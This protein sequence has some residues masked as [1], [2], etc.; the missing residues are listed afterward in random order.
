MKKLVRTTR[1]GKGRNGHYHIVYLNEDD[2]YGFTSAVNGQSHLVKWNPPTQYQPPQ[3]DQLGNLIAEEVPESPGFFEILPAEDGHTHEGFEEIEVKNPF[4]DDRPDTE[5]AQEVYQLFTAAAGIE[6]ESIEDGELAEEFVAG[7]QWDEV[8]L[9]KLTE[10][11]RAALT[12]NYIEH[13]IDE[14][15]GYQRNQRTD[16]KYLPK[17]G[18]DQVKADIFTHIAKHVLDKCNYIYEESEQFEDQAVPGRGIVTLDVSFDK[19]IRGDI[20]VRHLPWKDARF[21]PHKKK[22]LSDLEYYVLHRMY[23]HDHLTRMYEDK[24]DE[25]D[26]AVEQLDYLN[27]TDDTTATDNFSGEWRF[28]S[29]ISGLPMHN[30]ARKEIRVLECW[31]KLY[32]RASVLAVPQD[33]FYVSGLGWSKKDLDSAKTIP[34]MRVVQRMVTKIRITK[35]CR[36]V[37]LADELPADLP[38]DD[39]YIA[40][41]YA[42][43][44]GDRFW[45]KVKR[46]IDPQKELNKRRSQ[47]MDFGNRALGSG[48]FYDSSTFPD[49]EKQKFRKR[50]S[51]SGFFQ[52]VTSV[53][54]IPI[55]QDGPP[56]PPEI[57]SLSMQAQETIRDLISVQVEPQGANDSGSKLLTLEQMKLRGNEFLFDN[58]SLSKVRVGRLLLGLIK[59]YWSPERV[60]RLLMSKA[61]RDGN[62]QQDPTLG[63]KPVSEFSE[64]DIAQIYE[65]TDVESLDVVVSEAAYSPTIQTA[66]FLMFKELAADG[67]P[68]PPQVLVGLAPIPESKK[69][70]FLGLLQQQAEGQ[71]QDAQ[72]S[73]DAEIQKTLIAHGHIPPDVAQKYGLVQEGLGESPMPATEGGDS[74][75]GEPGGELPSQ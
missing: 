24:A 23:S 50:A 43:K 62:T 3:Y 2:G 6:Q 52:E 25:I 46:V 70:E 41:A 21:G 4:T 13:Q 35:V 66:T 59:R 71:S 73:A 69:Q 29:L 56:I 18:S 37:I 72:I 5:I 26:A 65:D 44:R 61:A 45:G 67:V 9:A 30:I 14:L 28:P 17:E 63:G 49:N 68:V 15:C 32:H 51:R 8:T 36:G 34:G 54:N 64:G 42:K 27:G 53:S 39:F 22:D 31:R 75:S 48:W 58:L 33:D 19:D 57:L 11:E 1:S 16:I 74:V 7:D 38:E 20:E 12:L 40:V 10:E 60:E 47:A 55:K